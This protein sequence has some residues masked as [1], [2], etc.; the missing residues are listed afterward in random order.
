MKAVKYWSLGPAGKRA[1]AVLALLL[2]P[3]GGASVGDSPL[4]WDP[5]E[6]EALIAYG[7]ALKLCEL[8]E[9]TNPRL[10]CYEAAKAV[11]LHTLEE[12]RRGQE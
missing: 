3:L 2:L 5:C 4:D 7:K 11:Y 9:N 8:A 12:C 1:F 6:R 10:R